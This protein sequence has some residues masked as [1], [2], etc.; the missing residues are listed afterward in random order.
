MGYAVVTL[1]ALY[2]LHDDGELRAA[3]RYQQGDPALGLLSGMLL[4]WVFVY[5]VEHFIAPMEFL[6]ACRVDGPLIDVPPAGGLRAVTEG[7]RDSACR[8]LGKS[9]A[10]APGPYR[11]LAV[12]G[13]AV[14]EE[15][16]WRGGVQRWLSEKIG[17]TRAMLTVAV[18]YPVAQFATGNITLGLVALP[19]SFVWAGLFR[20]R[21]SLAPT[22]LSHAVFSYLLFGLWAPFQLRN[23]ITLH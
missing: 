9:S 1:G 23:V 12:V 6:R 21:A 18:V 3:F 15:I 17:S 13:I 16:A 22:V 14:V 4:A 20:W 10:I 19:M 2:A 11:T 5:A 7:L 8:A